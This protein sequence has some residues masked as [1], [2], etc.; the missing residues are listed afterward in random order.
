MPTKKTKKEFTL[1][2]SLLCSHSL[3]DADTMN[4]SLINLIDQINI[5]ANRK[6]KSKEFNEKEGEV[7][8]I[9]MVL[10]SRFRKLI[11]ENTIVSVDVRYDVLDPKMKKL[12]S[13]ESSF[14][15]EK[16]IKNFRA[17]SHVN[18]FKITTSGMYAIVVNTK[19]LNDTKYTK[20]GSVPLDV[21]LKVT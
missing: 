20:V 13:F 2:W 11:D 4:A 12:G 18:G 8:P 6:D 3:T 17:A 19:K 16:G 10:V 15:M 7:F 1:E 5:N 9:N 14:T 21:N